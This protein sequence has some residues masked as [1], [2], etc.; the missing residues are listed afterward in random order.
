M[1]AKNENFDLGQVVTVKGEAGEWFIH[2]L[3][4][5]G[6]TALVLPMNSTKLAAAGAEPG[7]DLDYLAHVLHLAKIVPLSQIK[8]VGPVTQQMIESVVD[9]L[10][11]RYR[12]RRMVELAAKDINANPNPKLARMSSTQIEGYFRMYCAKYVHFR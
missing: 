6:E 10:R 2:T 3:S 4:V 9:D 11:E 7:N 5:H 1:A 8:N 12:D